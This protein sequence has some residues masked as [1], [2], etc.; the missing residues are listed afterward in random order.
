MGSPRA[1][2]TK[3]FNP[4]INIDQEDEA[5][6]NLIAAAPA[7]YEA[8]ESAMFDLEQEAEQRET[9]GNDE[10]SQGLRAAIATGA[11]ALK[12]ARGES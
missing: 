7:L 4:F 3:E 6:A 11:G 9:C 8:L 1:G 12:A 10:F 5:N 2:R